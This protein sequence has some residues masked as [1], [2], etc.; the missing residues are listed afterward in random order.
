MQATHIRPTHCIFL[1]LRTVHNVPQYSKLLTTTLPASSL[2]HQR[3]CH[4]PTQYPHP[5]THP[6]RSLHEL[7]VVENGQIAPA[8]QSRPTVQFSSKRTIL[9]KQALFTCLALDLYPSYRTIAEDRH[10]RSSARAMHNCGHQAFKYH[11]YLY[12]DVLYP[13]LSIP[14][15]PYHWPRK[16]DERELAARQ[17]WDNEITCTV[18]S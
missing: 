13:P 16:L 11:T 10:V 7:P 5:S 9:Y 18:D 4:V 14:T 2:I 8:L 3:S 17:P 1:L 15:P 6:H 12:I